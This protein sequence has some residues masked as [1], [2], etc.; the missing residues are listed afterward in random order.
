MSALALQQYQQIE[1][2]LYF[3]GDICKL[4]SDLG[5]HHCTSMSG[6]SNSDKD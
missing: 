6:K 1:D 4:S 2:W 5:K 3:P